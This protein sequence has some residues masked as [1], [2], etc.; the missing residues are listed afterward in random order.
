GMVEADAIGAK[1]AF[2]DK[3][4][5]R[6]PAY[7]GRILDTQCGALWKSIGSS[8]GGCIGSPKHFSR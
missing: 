2:Q 5:F 8:F 6:Y 3:N 7:F 4:A 1:Q